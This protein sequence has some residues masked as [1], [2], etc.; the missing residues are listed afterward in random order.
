MKKLPI[1][2]TGIY[3]NLRKELRLYAVVLNRS[4]SGDRRSIQWGI[5]ECA[6]WIRFLAE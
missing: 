6:V 2:L 5:S 1:Q 3:H 4:V